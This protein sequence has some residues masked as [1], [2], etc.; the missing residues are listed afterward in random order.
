MKNIIIGSLD[1]GIKVIKPM[2]CVIMSEMLITYIGHRGEVGFLP[3]KYLK[4][5]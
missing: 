5:K 4:I 1:K 2:I 3:E